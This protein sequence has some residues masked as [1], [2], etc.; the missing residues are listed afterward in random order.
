MRVI[1]RIR[2]IPGWV[3]LP[4]LPVAIITSMS[5]SRKIHSGTELGGCAETWI[6]PDPEACWD[7]DRVRND[8]VNRKSLAGIVRVSPGLIIYRQ[9]QSR[10]LRRH[11]ERRVCPDHESGSKT[12]ERA[13]NRPD[14]PR[15]AATKLLV[16]N[17]KTPLRLAQGEAVR[18]VW[19]GA[20][21]I[22]RDQALGDNRH[23]LPLFNWNIQRTLATGREMLP[24]LGARARSG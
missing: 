10:R 17:K 13:D 1:N 5:N 16:E 3:R 9:L 24:L 8:E 12:I 15:K 20:I 21:R 7:K 6:W 14:R 18:A 4:P 22:N 23:D 2:D 11:R 19:R